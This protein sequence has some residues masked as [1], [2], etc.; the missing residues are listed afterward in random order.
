MT[1]SR[2]SSIQDF[3]FRKSVV[4]TE[5]HFRFREFFHLTDLTFESRLNLFLQTTNPRSRCTYD[6]NLCENIK[7]I[8]SFELIKVSV[9][10]KAVLKNQL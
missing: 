8:Q 1:I 4:A 5:A 7:L 10:A 3:V 9:R 6:C 2:F